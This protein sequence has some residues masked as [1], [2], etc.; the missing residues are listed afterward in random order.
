MLLQ[1][2]PE[3][4]AVWF[5]TFTKRTYVMKQWEKLKFIICNIYDICNIKIPEASGHSDKQF[6]WDATNMISNVCMIYHI[7]VHMIHSMAMV[8]LN[9][10]KETMPTTTTALKIAL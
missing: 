10:S 1:K 5:F 9:K 8:N 6:S 4:I 3:L 7:K 2:A